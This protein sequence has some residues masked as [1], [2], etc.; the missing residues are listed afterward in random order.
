M[1]KIKFKLSKEE[2]ISLMWAM[3]ISC[4]QGTTKGLTHLAAIAILRKLYIKLLG[5]N[6][7]LKIKNNSISFTIIELWALIVQI[8]TVDH[9]M[10]TYEKVLINTINGRA[11]RLTS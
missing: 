7:T 4:N 5:R 2:I 3:E 11:H 10:G 9:L 6:A 1:Q 8:Q